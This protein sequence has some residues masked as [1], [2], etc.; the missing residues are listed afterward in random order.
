M[1]DKEVEDMIKLF[2]SLGIIKTSGSVRYIKKTKEK[3]QEILKDHF[4]IK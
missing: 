4:G 2:T 1:L 3:S